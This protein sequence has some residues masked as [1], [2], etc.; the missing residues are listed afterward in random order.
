MAAVTPE[1]IAKFARLVLK[2]RVA[3]PREIQLEITNRCNLDCDMCPR[4][5]VLGVPEEDMADEVF[6]AVLGRLE[7]PRR[8]TLTGWGEPLMHPGFFD[9]SDQI[10][11]RFPAC[12]LGFTTNGLLLSDGICEKIAA[13]PYRQ[14]NISLEEL[15]FDEQGAASEPLHENPMKGHGNAIARKG[16]PATTRL[17]EGLR[18]LIEKTRRRPQPP[19]LRLQ[20]VLFPEGLSILLRL[21]DYAAE[22]GFDA[23][24]LV[25]LDPRGHDD[26]QRPGLEEEGVMIAAA[27]RR[28]RERGIAIESVNDH[29]LALRLASHDDRFCIRLDDYAYVTVHGEVSA[30]CLL[31]NKSLGDLRHESLRDVW[32]SPA[33]QRYY[34]DQLPEDCAGCDAFMRGHAQPVSPSTQALAV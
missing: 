32:Q 3:V 4:I 8:I 26:L 23:V 27:R 5:S 25:R 20:A 10:F 18:R 16:H 15:P 19:L 2:R 30:C 14:I 22:E 21:I 17:V 33:M 6:R 11:E 12:E 31:R 29:G 24:N 1:R 34:G 13:R 28:G 7:T 9:Y